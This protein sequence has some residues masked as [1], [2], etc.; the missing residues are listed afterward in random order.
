MKVF[1]LVAFTAALLTLSAA[2]ATSQPAPVTSSAPTL[3]RSKI[4]FEQPFL[5]DLISAIRR[6]GK[7]ARIY[8]A[9]TCAPGNASVDD[10][11]NGN[12]TFT[13]PDVNIDLSREPLTGV[14]SIRYILR[15]DAQATVGQGPSGITRI[16]VGD[17]S[18]AILQTK[19]SRLALSKYGQYTA[20]SAVE[21]LLRAQELLNAE[22]RTH[23]RLRNHLID[24]LVG[25]G[26]GPHLPPLLR[27]VTI[28]QALDAIAQ[29]FNGIVLYGNCK[30][31]DASRSFDL[32]FIYN[33]PPLSATSSRAGSGR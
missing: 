3:P 13:Y 6:V 23:V 20:L 17:V 8:L 15:N 14:S 11:L 1:T 27:D 2:K 9:A 30:M 4:Q 21:E 22:L 31:P 26:S 24:H 12:M 32:R 16:T 10:V 19:I 28:D 29:T 25:W 33:P 18:T 5:D 7:P